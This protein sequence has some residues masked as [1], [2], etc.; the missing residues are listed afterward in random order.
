MDLWKCPLEDERLKD[1]L[2]DKA[3]MVGDAM[4]LYENDVPIGGHVSD[5]MLVNILYSGSLE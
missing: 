4:P 1:L 5:T 2:E 3:L